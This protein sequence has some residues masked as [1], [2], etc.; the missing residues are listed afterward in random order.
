MAR[1]TIPTGSTPGWLR[2]VERLVEELEFHVV[3]ARRLSVHVVH[4]DGPEGGA[5]RCCR[6]PRIASICFWRRPKP[7]SGRRGG[8]ATRRPTDARQRRPSCG[9]PACIQ[10]GL[11]DP[12]AGEGPTVAKVKREVNGRLGR[13]ALRSGATLPLADVYRDEAQGYDICDVQRQDVLLKWGRGHVCR[14]GVGGQ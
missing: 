10:P 1:L 11:F 9:G 7:A 13:F 8:R 14:R 3:C 6:R 4:K 2:N 12:P 5:Q